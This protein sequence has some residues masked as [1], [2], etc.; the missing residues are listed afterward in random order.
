MSSG[1]VRSLLGTALLLLV[2][3]LGWLGWQTLDRPVTV[4]RV[5]GE[6]TTAERAR[7]TELVS[8]FLPAG[9]LSLD[10]LALRDLLEAES[11]VDSVALWRSWPDGI[12][13]EIRAEAAVARWRTDAL[14]SA[15]GRIIEPLE[16]MGLDALPRLA[17]PDGSAE[18]VMQTFQRIADVLRPHGLRIETL[19]MDAEGGIEVRLREGPL[20]VFGRRDLAARLQRLDLVLRQQFPDGLADVE[21]IDTRY[22]NGVAVGWRSADVGRAL[23]TRQLAKGS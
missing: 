1:I 22:D 15:R 16:L 19:D 4:V 20:L 12:R 21:R 3:V 17:G 9:V 7:A 10:T 14:L 6:L 8:L 13:L 11:W 2:L 5:D 23:A 18:W